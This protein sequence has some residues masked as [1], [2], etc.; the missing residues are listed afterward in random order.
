MEDPDAEHV[1][2]KALCCEPDGTKSLNREVVKSLN[3][4]FVDLYTTAACRDCTF[5]A[6]SFCILLRQICDANSPDAGGSS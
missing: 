2:T 5:I 1:G 4:H 6:A 3:R